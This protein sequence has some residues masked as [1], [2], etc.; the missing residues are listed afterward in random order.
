MYCCRCAC[1]RGCA[2][3]APAFAAAGWEATGVLSCKGAGS[4]GA[5]CD[6]AGCCSVDAAGS[7][8]CC[9]EAGLSPARVRSNLGTRIAPTTKTSNDHHR[10][11]SHVEPA[12]AGT[13][14]RRSCLRARTERLPP[15]SSVAAWPRRPQERARQRWRWR[16]RKPSADW[17]RFAGSLAIDIRMIS[18]S[19]AGS[20]GSTS[21]GGTGGFSRCADMMEKSLSPS[22][23]RAPVTISYSD[24][25]SEYRSDRGSS[26]PPLICSGD[27]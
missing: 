12:T 4:A 25:P 19:A 26:S 21:I 10:P 6:G 17:K 27:M 23:G 18:F 2:C 8:S 3:P 13:A 22:N 9:V 14:A 1:G 5:G 15:P 16:P 24:T 11:Q 7:D 20:R